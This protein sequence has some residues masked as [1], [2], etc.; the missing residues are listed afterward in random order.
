MSA[1]EEGEKSVVFIDE[2]Q[3]L[4]SPSNFLKLIYDEYREKVKLVASGSSAFYID[5]KFNDSLAGR[6]RVF[7]MHT[8]SFG[9][10]L[11]LGGKDELYAEY[12]RIAATPN[13]LSKALPLLEAELRSYMRFGGYPAVV[14][15]RDEREKALILAELRDSFLKRDVVEA[16]VQNAD[17]FYRLFRLLAAQSG[18]LMNTNELAKMLRMKN[19][20]VQRYIDVMNK[21]CHIGIVRPFFRNIGKELTKMPKLYVLDSGMRRSLLGTLQTEISPIEEGAVWEGVIYRALLERHDMD[22]LNFWRTTAGNEVDFVLPH[23]AQPF[24]VEVKHSLG[25]AR[26]SKYA[27]FIASYPDIPLRFIEGFPLSEKTVCYL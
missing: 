7:R 19:D 27:T 8:C 18:S 26:A 2:V 4:D 21:C 13:A 12:S 25:A 5:S 10:H 14:T 17:S 20:T 23:A 16:G 9:E 11:L 24:A 1:N 3:Y 22:E 15:E 6:K